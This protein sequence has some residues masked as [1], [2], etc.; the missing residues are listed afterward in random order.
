[1]SIF[2][3][4]FF[5]YLLPNLLVVSWN[6]VGFL[7]IFEFTSLTQSAVRPTKYL[8]LVILAWERLNLFSEKWK[9]AS[10]KFLEE[11]LELISSG[12]ILSFDDRVSHCSLENQR[13]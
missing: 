6:E 13:D 8:L 2:A 1:V 12:S 3:N 4:V 7:M 9:I 11:L 10:S 5:S